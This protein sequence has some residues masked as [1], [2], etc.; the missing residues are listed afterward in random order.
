MESCVFCVDHYTYKGGEGINGYEGGGG[1]VNLFDCTQQLL[2]SLSP[3]NT[4]YVVQYTSEPATVG[5]VQQKCFSTS[6]LL[7]SYSSAARIL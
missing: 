3:K 6:L 7:F 4:R 2:Q 5:S 1:G